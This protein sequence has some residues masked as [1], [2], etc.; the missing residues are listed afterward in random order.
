MDGELDRLLHSIVVRSR[1]R[2]K[3]ARMEHT[4]DV[5]QLRQLWDEQGARCAVSGVAFSDERVPA[6][7][8]SRPFA[9]SLDRIDC[10]RG[11]VPD[12]V[13]LVCTVANFALGQWGDSIV[14]RL[15]HGIVET[16]RKAERQWFAEQRRK[17]KRAEKAAE[18]LIG[19]ALARQRSTVA[20]LKATLT[21]GPARLSGAGIRSW[22]SRKDPPRE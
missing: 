11:Y 14:R 22:I 5:P 1:G 19:E 12:N 6:A 4:V 21:K 9:P 17:L 8:V 16:E 20:G 2:A 13:R 3:R 15:A 18:G 10:S 7:F